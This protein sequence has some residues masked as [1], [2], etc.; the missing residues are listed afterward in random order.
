MDDASDGL[1][2]LRPVTFRYKQPQAD[3]SKPVDYGLI[4]EEVAQVYPE[5]AA[6]NARGDS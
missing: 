5:M 3:G 6:R 4:T 1:F 2:R